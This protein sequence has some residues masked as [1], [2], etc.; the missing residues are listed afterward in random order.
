ML[1]DSGRRRLTKLAERTLGERASG[2]NLQRQHPHVRRIPHH[3][4]G[5]NGAGEDIYLHVRRRKCTG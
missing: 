3:L 5:G 4:R 2:A 1:E